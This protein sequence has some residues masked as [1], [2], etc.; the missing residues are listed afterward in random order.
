MIETINTADTVVMAGVPTVEKILRA[1][2]S[3]VTDKG[4]INPVQYEVDELTVSN[5][6]KKLAG[7]EWQDVYKKIEELKIIR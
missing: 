4:D 2:V 3:K 7:K 1:M 5:D 6:V